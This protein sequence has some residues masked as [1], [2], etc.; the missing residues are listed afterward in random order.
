MLFSVSNSQ[1]AVLWSANHGN[2]LWIEG[3]TGQSCLYLGQEYLAIV[4]ISVFTC[5]KFTG[6]EK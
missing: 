2:L 6:C 3:R 1:A 4:F 5:I